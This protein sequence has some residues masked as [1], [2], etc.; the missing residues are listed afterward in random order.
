MKDLKLI[1]ENLTKLVATIPDWNFI[2]Y[3]DRKDIVSN[4]LEQIYKKY[5]EGKITGEFN[6]IKGYNFITLRNFC[7]QFKKKNRVVYSDSNFSH[8]EDDIPYDDIEYKDKLKRIVR[9]HYNSKKMNSEL[10]LVAEMLFDNKTNEEISNE[11]GISN[12]IVGRRKHQL[13]LKLRN[14]HQKQ[15]KFL[16]KK[17]DDPKYL[18]ACRSELDVS[19]HFPDEKFKYVKERIYNK[20]KFRDGRFIETVE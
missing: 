20:Q 7:I 5:A 14:L 10:I 2:N 17:I 9:S 4:A 18:I 11:L 16:I 13:A 6:D 3:E 12:Y 15:T 19:R 8:I 1:I